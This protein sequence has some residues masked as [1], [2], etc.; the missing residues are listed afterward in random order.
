MNKNSQSRSI[1]QR[2][3]NFMVSV[4]NHHAQDVPIQEGSSRN[5][6]GPINGP[7]GDTGSEI[8]VVFRHTN[9]GSGRWIDISKQEGYAILDSKNDGLISING[10]KANDNNI[11]RFVNYKNDHKKNNRAREDIKAWPLVRVPSNINEKSDE[12]IK[13]RKKALSRSYSFE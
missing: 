2:L 4:M 1:C 11:D 6:A 5:K 12:Y 10:N 8:V 7:K 13:S 9:N 3:I